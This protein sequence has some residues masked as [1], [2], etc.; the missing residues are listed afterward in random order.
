MAG[1]RKNLVKKVVHAFD[2]SNNAGTYA[3]SIIGI[4]NS[5]ELFRGELNIKNGVDL[6]QDTGLEILQ[7]SSCQHL[8]LRSRLKAMHYCLKY[9]LNYK[10]F[11]LLSVIF[12]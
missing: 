2:S 8:L 9:I 10:S 7:R 6:V 11:Y 4:A 5:V 3:I 1:S 12:S